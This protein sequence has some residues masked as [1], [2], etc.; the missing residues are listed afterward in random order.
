MVFT[1]LVI[2]LTACK[3]S[4][5]SSIIG[6]WQETKIRV[7][8]TG[9]TGAIVSD[10]T[11]TGQTFTNL[12][13]TQFNSTGTVVMSTDHIYFPVGPE[14]LKVP[15]YYLSAETLNYTSSGSNYILLPIAKGSNN[16][17]ELPGASQAITATVSGPNNL[18]IH[19]V[20]YFTIPAVSTMVYD[21]YYTR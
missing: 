21:S 17:N 7:Y 3:K 15:P 14:F 1:G 9:P 6:K 10:T 5:K 11:Y 4:N 20:D 2:M 13:Y 16:N 12:D 19:M 18:L 8:M